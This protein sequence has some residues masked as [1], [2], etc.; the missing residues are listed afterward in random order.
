MPRLEPSPG[1]P[2]P[3]IGRVADEDPL[4]RAEE[5]AA[6]ESPAGL[7]RALGALAL[8]ADSRRVALAVRDDYRDLLVTLRQLA[9]DTRIEIVSVPARYPRDNDSLRC[10]VAAALDRLPSAYEGAPVFD[11]LVLRDV[12]TALDGAQQPDRLVSVVGAVSRPVTRALPLGCSIEDAVAAAGGIAAGV[13]AV[14]WVAYEN[15]LL[16]GLR[17]DADDVVDLATRSLVILPATHPRVREDAVPLAD[18]V[19][20]AAAACLQCQ[21]CREGCPV[22]LTRGGLQ[23][24]LLTRQLARGFAGADAP[25]PPDEEASALAS[26]TCIGCGSCT[27][28]CPSNVDPARLVRAT[29]AQLRDSGAVVERPLPLAPRVERADRL[30]SLA[31]LRQLYQP[32]SDA[33]GRHAIDPRPFTPSLV[34][35]P[36]RDPR[37]EARPALVVRGDELRR[38]EPVTRQ[39]PSAVALFAPRAGVVE[40][41]D[42]DRGLLLRCR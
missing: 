39:T 28:R 13:S 30:L 2:T 17:R 27:L 11:A 38:G 29:A 6:R 12:A 26:L 37:G 19:R 10:D 5:A 4:C 32:F 9:A 3:L 14:A 7:L 40:A 18:R 21:V 23:P 42:P 25:L 22:W 1:A 41:I 24:H 16:G 34:A 35:L 15:G 8:L 20:Q 31:R 33:E 36:L